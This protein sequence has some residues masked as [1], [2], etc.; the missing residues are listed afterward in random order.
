MT[1]GYKE[2]NVLFGNP[3]NAD[4]SENK[5]W[6]HAHIRFVKPPAGWNYTARAIVVH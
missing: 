3:A 5:T 2:T 6:V 1:N 4:G